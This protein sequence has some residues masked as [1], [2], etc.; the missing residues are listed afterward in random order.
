MTSFQIISSPQLKVLPTKRQV[1][2]QKPRKRNYHQ[3]NDFS[4]VSSLDL[5]FSKKICRLHNPYFQKH[6]NNDTVMQFSIFLS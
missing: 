3:I 1:K 2:N 5:N 4:E 6:K